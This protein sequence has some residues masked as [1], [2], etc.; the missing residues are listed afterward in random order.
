MSDKIKPHHLERKAILY[1]RQS[2]SHQVQHT[3]ARRRR[4][5]RAEWLAL[6]PGAHDGYVDWEQAEAIRRMV[7]DNVPASR[8][9]NRWTRERVTA[10]RSHH[11]IP[12]H[13]PAPNG[14]EPWLNL[15]RAAAHLRIGAKTLRLA[16]ENGEIQAL[17]PLP[18]GPWLFSRAVLDGPAAKTVVERAH[19]RARHPTGPHPAQ[20][21]LFSSM[22]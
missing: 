9:G 3:R 20:Q 5:P 18:D 4:R 15:T 10:L 12:V 6:Q 14:H 2:S 11:K 13:R 22:T 8:H 17:H 16:A 19:Q 7:S 21:N 1:V